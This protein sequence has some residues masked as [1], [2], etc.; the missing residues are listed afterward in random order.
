MGVLGRFAACRMFINPLYSRVTLI[1]ALSLAATLATLNRIPAVF[2]QQ[3]AFASSNNEASAA[4]AKQALACL[5]RGE[6]EPTT[7]ARL[8]A[9]RDGVKFAERAVAAD[10]SNADAH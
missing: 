9:Y 6:D 8:A 4:L 5:R 2:A 1:F 10:D 7:E 3:A